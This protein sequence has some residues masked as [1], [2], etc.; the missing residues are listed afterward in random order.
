[1]KIYTLINLKWI[2][3]HQSE[4]YKIS[5]VKYH[6][7]HDVSMDK[8]CQIFGC[9]KRSLKRWIE[10]FKNEKK[11]LKRHISLQKNKLKENEQITLEEPKNVL[12]ILSKVRQRW[13]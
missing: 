3:K 9:K 13:K 1:M 7:N 12:L 2:T 11:S 10:R 4:D 6:I 5:A 8:E